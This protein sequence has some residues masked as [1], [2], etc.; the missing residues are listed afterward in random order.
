MGQQIVVQQ[1]T[2]NFVAA[3]EVVFAAVGAAIISDPAEPEVE[4]ES[5][6]A[7]SATAASAPEGTAVGEIYSRA[8]AGFSFAGVPLTPAQAAARRQVGRRECGEQQKQVSR[9]CSRRKGE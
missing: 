1:S 3:E 6:A 2:I 9:H 7:G 4:P 5:T 8:G